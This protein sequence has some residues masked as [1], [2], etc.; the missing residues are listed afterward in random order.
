MRLSDHSLGIHTGRQTRPRTP[1][2]LRFCKKYPG[3]IED[4]A[5]FLCECTDDSNIKSEF[6]KAIAMSYPDIDNIANKQM[7]YKSIMK[8]KDPTSLKSLGFLVN[9]LFNNRDQ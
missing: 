3:T 4:E 5:H 6:F 7:K 2:E 8:I 1:P 9:L